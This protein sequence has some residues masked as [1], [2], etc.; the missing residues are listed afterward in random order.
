MH[1]SNPG[2]AKIIK[3]MRQADNM[4]TNIMLDCHA[5]YRGSC[6]RELCVSRKHDDAVLKKNEPILVWAH[7]WMSLDTSYLLLFRVC[8]QFVQHLN[9]LYKAKCYLLLASSESVA[10]HW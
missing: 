1:D 2:V 8:F 4:L 6:L 7:K 3:I 10:Y 9:S 5:L